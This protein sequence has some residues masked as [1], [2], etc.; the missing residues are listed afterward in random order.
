VLLLLMMILELLL[1][2]LVSQN[3]RS[4]EN[5]YCP[6]SIAYRKFQHRK[7]ENYS[8]TYP[9]DIFESSFDQNGNY[10]SCALMDIFADNRAAFRNGTV[11]S[12]ARYFQP[13]G[14]PNGMHKCSQELRCPI[15]EEDINLFLSMQTWKP[16]MSICEHYRHVKNKHPIDILIFGGSV[17]HG[18]YSRGCHPDSPAANCP[19]QRYMQPFLSFL[20]HENIRLA[21]FTTPGRSSTAAAANLE[22]K[23]M[24]ENI[25]L[26]TSSILLVDFSMNDGHQEFRSEIFIRKVLELADGV[27]PVI[28]LINT[29]FNN[30]ASCGAAAQYPPTGES[31][32]AC[33]DEITAIER[34]YQAVAKHYGVYYW[35]FLQ[36][37]YAPR[38]YDHLPG[39]VHYARF[40]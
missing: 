27:L 25:T 40:R 26:S 33:Y 16:N 32:K 20:Y 28:V 38:M 34:R 24:E 8:Y 18:G 21:D 5:D 35:S 1:L 12:M 31:E 23:I 11:F 29:G 17:T 14:G 13:H 39:F 37:A 9:V 4:I 19:W 30:M 36:T 22:R 2:I 15:D 6:A 7:N 3:C 10:S